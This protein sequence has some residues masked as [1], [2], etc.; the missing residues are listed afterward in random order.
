MSVR[1]LM[2]LL[3]FWAVIKSYSDQKLLLDDILNIIMQYKPHVGK[4]TTK[5]YANMFGS[6]MIISIKLSKDFNVAQD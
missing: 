2:I 1:M 5:Y 4:V 6:D 3:I